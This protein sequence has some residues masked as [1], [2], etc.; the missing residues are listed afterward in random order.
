MCHE[1]TGEYRTESK[2][3]EIS[4]AWQERQEVPQIQLHET[5]ILPDSSQT[6]SLCDRVAQIESAFDK[7]VIVRSK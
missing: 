2:D 5:D 6:E 3:A 4:N 1:D 7:R